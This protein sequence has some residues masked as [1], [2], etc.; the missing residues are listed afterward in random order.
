MASEEDRLF[1][2]V[3]R[4]IE[5]LAVEQP[6][7]RDASNQKSWPVPAAPSVKG[8]IRGAFELKCYS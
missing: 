8:R 4:F 6:K 3:L 1:A 7:W 5:K 2:N